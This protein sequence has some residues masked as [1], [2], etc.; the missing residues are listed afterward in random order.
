MPRG[1]RYSDLEIENLKARV[2]E[3][4]AMPVKQ[5]AQK[6]GIGCELVMA[7]RN[8]TVEA[9]RQRNRDHRNEYQQSLPRSAHYERCP[10]CR[11]KTLM[12]CLLCASQRAKY[13]EPLGGSGRPA[14][15]LT[16]GALDGSV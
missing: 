1:R 7:L 4:P 8:D 13:G 5:L 2:E 12:P 9:F 11:G 10:T 14:Y 3:C 6:L 15:R 16:A